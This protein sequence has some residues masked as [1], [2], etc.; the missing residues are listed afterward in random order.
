VSLA[1]GVIGLGVMGRNLALNFAEHGARVVAFDTQA[2]ARERMAAAAREQALAV[3]VMESVDTLVAALPTPRQIL[4]M[5]PA[6]AP[7]DAV[8]AA[9]TP[10]LA[11]GDAIL[12]GGNSHPNDSE[13]R[14][15]ALENAGL[16]FLGIGVSGGEEGARN[17]PA[18]MPGGSRQAFD[19]VRP[20]LEA[21]AATAHGASCC[22]FMGSGGA[23][24]YVK[25][26]HNGIEYGD[27]QLIAEAYALLRDGLGLSH[28]AMHAV[29]AQYASGVLDSYLIDITRDILATRDAHGQ[30]LV[31]RILDRAEQ[32]GT[33][34]WTA[35]SALALGQPATLATEAVFARALSHMKAT[36]VRSSHLPGPHGGAPGE[37][38]DAVAFSADLEAA[39]YASKIVGYTQGYL[40]LRAASNAHGWGIDLA[41]TARVWR[42]GCI[43][44]SRFLGDIAAAFERDPTLE[45]LLL[46]PFFT[47]AMAR[48]HAAWRRVLA[49]GI[50]WGVPLPAMGA[51]LAF[52][53]GLRTANSAANL[54]QAQRDFF[55]AHT[56]V[57]RDDPSETPVHHAWTQGKR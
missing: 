19:R 40:L 22:A 7:V 41:A 35:E 36:R 20:L 57:W 53:D 25:M 24:H 14:A 17:G 29:F 18:L 2:S 26:V 15:H 42:G 54:L 49:L 10:L 38:T 1:I 34:R 5:V 23:G 33:G 30:P 37:A 50:Q 12:D 32:K 45:H 55:G 9:L 44:R 4:L 56:F 48:A 31:A 43:I 27:M 13:R 3:A 16:H 11:A 21:V 46:A 28:D 52:Y 6:G 47:E 51:A 39:L 8:I